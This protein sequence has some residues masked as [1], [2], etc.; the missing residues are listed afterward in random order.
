MLLQ[1]AP[2]PSYP[3]VEHD[4]QISS[5]S[6]P[7]TASNLQRNTSGS[8][9]SGQGCYSSSSE[10]NAAYHSNLLKPDNG[11][12]FPLNGDGVDGN[13][14]GEEEVDTDLSSNI[15]SQAHDC[16]TL[17]GSGGVGG[18]GEKTAV[19]QA[20][21]YSD[22]LPMSALPSQTSSLLMRR[23][24]HEFDAEDATL[25]SLEEEHQTRY[26]K[27]D[28]GEQEQEKREEQYDQYAPFPTAPLSSSSSFSSAAPHLSP[29]PTYAPSSHNL[30]PTVSPGILARSSSTFRRRKDPKSPLKIASSPLQSPTNTRRRSAAA[31]RQLSTATSPIITTRSS[32]SGGTSSTTRTTLSPTLRSY[33][34][35]SSTALLGEVPLAIREDQDDASMTPHPCTS[36]P[37][38]QSANTRSS[39]PF[40]S[41]SPAEE[42]N[43]PISFRLD[44]GVLPLG[45][46]LRRSVETGDVT[47]H[48]DT[49]AV[50][51]RFSANS[52]GA[53]ASNDAQSD[54]LPLPSSSA[55]T[56]AAERP[57]PATALSVK[58]RSLLS[59]L[60][61]LNTSALS[62]SSSSSSS[63]SPYVG[64][65]QQRGQSSPPTSPTS[66]TTT[67]TRSVPRSPLVALSAARE[68]PVA[69]TSSMRPSIRQR[70][71]SRRSSTGPSP[72][73]P[74]AHQHRVTIL[75]PPPPLPKRTSTGSTGW[76]YDEGQNHQQNQQDR[77]GNGDEEEEGGVESMTTTP[78][79]VASAPGAPFS[80]FNPRDSVG[81]SSSTATDTERPSRSTTQRTNSFP[82]LHNP[83]NLSGLGMGRNRRSRSSQRASVVPSQQDQSGFSGNTALAI[84]RL[85]T[86]ST[87]ASAPISVP[88]SLSGSSQSAAGS[89]VPSDP[90][91]VP[92]SPVVNRIS[93]AFGSP[94]L[95]VHV[96]ASSA[97]N[98]AR[99][100]KEK[101]K[102]LAPP[103]A[104]SDSLAVA[105][106]PIVGKIKSTTSRKAGKKEPM[107]SL[108]P[109]QHSHHLHHRR[110]P[111]T[112]SSI[113]APSSPSIPSTSLSAAPATT[114][115]FT[116]SR[117]ASPRLLATLSAYNLSSG[118]GHYLDDESS[119]SEDEKDGRLSEDA[120]HNHLQYQYNGRRSEDGSALTTT[121][122]TTANAIGGYADLNEEE[123]NWVKAERRQSRFL[124]RAMGIQDDLDFVYVLEGIRRPHFEELH[125]HQHPPPQNMLVQQQRQ[126]YGGDVEMQAVISGGNEDGLVAYE[127]GAEKGWKDELQ[128]LF[129]VS[130]QSGLDTLPYGIGTY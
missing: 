17:T 69:T 127:R 3:Y 93:A 122:S 80:N 14:N 84:K 60:L 63:P 65:H 59:S 34:H 42:P 13:D 32:S 54:A 2:D 81:S 106:S 57:S 104:A 94:P 86:A 87:S 111:S 37:M 7:D 5:A 114:P 58:R 126:Q 107:F 25:S 109:D 48:A 88:T 12:L 70:A 47:Y 95:S 68:T 4:N 28:Q 67:A 23:S 120:E 71:F 92:S 20:K 27:Q 100:T 102:S 101:R 108:D 116:F 35:N 115:P 82:F 96:I 77:E 21:V 15:S 24:S 26:L 1:S 16:S 117:P 123:K 130:Y 97:T 129:L 36:S 66:T 31:M 56:R 18:G 44:D 91:P 22:S 119:A 74:K 98:N 103:A 19:F 125:L 6:T 11:P 90:L 55:S 62:F 29:Y 89:S 49:G 113:S 10:E 78:R 39:F 61:P 75:E 9:S 51:S 45:A 124:S 118:D 105:S 76:E 41:P 73:S 50:E 38:L 8:S 30:L 64:T 99:D 121:T 43:S 52:N 53:S 112:N 46:A 72:K 33:R 83:L 40:Y 85:S 110:D 79:P 128:T